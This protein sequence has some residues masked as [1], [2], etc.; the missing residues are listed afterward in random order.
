LKSNSL[1]AI[2]NHSSYGPTFGE[3]CDMFVNGSNV[4]FNK[5]GRT[6][7]AGPLS[8][9]SFTIKEIEVFHVNALLPPARFAY[10]TENQANH[11]TVPRH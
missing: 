1:H 2:R 9:G 8:D 5:L 11:H 3:G 7:Y 6:Y 4:T 10:S